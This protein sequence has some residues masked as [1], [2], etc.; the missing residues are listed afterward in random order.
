VIW[1]DTPTKDM[2]RALAGGIVTLLSQ[3][4]NMIWKNHIGNGYQGQGD[5]ET[6]K[7]F[8]P[9]QLETARRIS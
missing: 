9:K 5:T 3:R 1:F 4:R 6:P 2:K 8:I 7:Q